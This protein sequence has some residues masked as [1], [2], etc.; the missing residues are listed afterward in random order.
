MLAVNDAIRLAPWA[1]VL[2]AADTSWWRTVGAQVQTKA[3]KI[4]CQDTEF[5][6]VNVL[7][8]R[9]GVL[10]ETDPHWVATGRRADD[11]GVMQGGNS[12]HQAVNIALHLGASRVVLLGYDM[13]AGPDGELHW[14]GRHPAPLNNPKVDNLARWRAALDDLAPLL[15]EQGVEVV[16]CSRRSALT[17]YRRA[18]LEEV[19]S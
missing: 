8:Y 14:F 19:F 12:G 9:R 11:R 2:Y 4:C 5:R 15:T 17:A 1:D 6:D 3:L 7:R 13:G 18:P 10:L 16:N